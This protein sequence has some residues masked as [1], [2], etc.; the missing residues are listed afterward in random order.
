MQNPDDPQSDELLTQ[1]NSID[2]QFYYNV[3]ATVLSGPMT[4][5]QITRLTEIM[6]MI[7]DVNNTQN[8]SNTQPESESEP[9]AD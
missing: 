9:N 8:Q 5:A 3:I 7:Q 4:Q 6:G 1:I 2:E